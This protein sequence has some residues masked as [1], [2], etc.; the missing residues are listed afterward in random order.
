MAK[1][2]QVKLKKSAWIGII[3][4]VLALILF[5]ILLI[6]TEKESIYKK[7]SSNSEFVEDH[8]IDE[9]SLNKFE[10]LLEKSGEE[11]VYVLYSTVE[12]VTENIH[13]FNDLALDNGIEKIYW[14]D[15]ANDKINDDEEKEEFSTY[16]RERIGKN[17]NG[18]DLI[19][20][21]YLRKVNLGTTL[22]MFVFQNGKI[23]NRYYDVTTKLEGK[24]VEYILK[25]YMYN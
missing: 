12:S 18:V 2:Q 1:P 13:L 23:V 24:S 9:V 3:V 16:L 21:N 8:I 6:P 10:K 4:T 25:N 7:F 14:L 11:K 17:E 5:V 22:D 15:A 19:K 20:R